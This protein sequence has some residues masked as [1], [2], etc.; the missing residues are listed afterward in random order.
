MPRYEQKT[1]GKLIVQ[2]WNVLNTYS[3]ENSL[4]Y[5]TPRQMAALVSLAEFLGWKTRYENPPEQ[6][7]L[8]AFTAETRYNLMTEISFCA[9][10]IAC[11]TD[12]DDVRNALNQWFIDQLTI[13]GDVYNAIQEVYQRNVGGQPMPPTVSGANTLPEIEDCDMDVLFGAIYY[14]IDTMNTAN[15]DAFEISEEVTNALERADLLMSAIPIFETLPIDEVLSYAETIWTDDLFEAYI[16]NDTDTY[17]DTIKCDL[18]CIARDN[19]CALSIDDMFD[20]F[21]V[22]IAGDP[23]SDFAQLVTYL[24]TGTWTGTQVNDM[25]FAGQLMFMKYGNQY[26]PYI[27]VKN[28]KTLMAIGARTPNDTWSLI[29]DD[30]PQTWCVEWDFTIGQIVDWNIA[31]GEYDEGEGFITDGVGD[32]PYTV[33]VGIDC[34]D[35]GTAD[36]TEIVIDGYTQTADGTGIKGAYYPPAVIQ[37]TVPNTDTGEW[38][39]NIEVTTVQPEQIR[40]QVSNN[41]V[42]GVNAIRKVRMSGN[43]ELPEFLMSGEIC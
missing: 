2:D 29:C 9:L 25:F 17:R 4:R 21:M 28:Y 35:W 30:C 24:I 18:R 39:A 15:I 20:Y 37:D 31:A 1:A 6:D 42:P 5:I 13:E 16:A 43:G 22:R 14:A 12:D 26:F 36:V 41:T 7:V 27:G 34:G 23:T 10:V 32:F 8:D 19:G 11:I 38:S 3:D 40:I 33:D